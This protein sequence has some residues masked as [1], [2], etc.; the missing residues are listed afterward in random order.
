MKELA[1]LIKMCAKAMDDEDA[2]RIA[3]DET[4]WKAV[5]SNW[6][7]A[8]RIICQNVCSAARS[9]EL[10]TPIYLMLGGAWND[11][12]EWAEEYAQ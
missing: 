9:P 5:A 11:A 1:Q 12:L 4:E 6:T 2:R 7:T 10:A 3:A 8:G